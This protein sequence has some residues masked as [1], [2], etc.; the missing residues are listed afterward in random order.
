MTKTP[1]RF[2]VIMIAVSVVVMMAWV[3]LG[4]KYFDQPRY[5]YAC[6]YSGSGTVDGK[7]VEFILPTLDVKSC[8]EEA[9]II[10]LHV[11]KN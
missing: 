8:R 6:F 10:K 2:E 9:T 11:V 5:L 7:D 1:T 4:I 3:D